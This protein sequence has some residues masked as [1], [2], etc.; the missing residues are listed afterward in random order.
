[1]QKYLD[2][3]H[4]NIG[5]CKIFDSFNFL[6]IEDQKKIN[7]LYFGYVNVL[8]I[9]MNNEIDKWLALYFSSIV[10][11]F[12]RSAVISMHL[13]LCIYVSV[14]LLWQVEL[15]KCSSQDDFFFSLAFC[16][17]YSLYKCCNWWKKAALNHWFPCKLRSKAW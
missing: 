11:F 13:E 7:D 10:C 17:Q 8:N 3:F 6:C 4:G 12:C 2:Y 9:T 1:M 5:H 14:W 16:Q 15:K